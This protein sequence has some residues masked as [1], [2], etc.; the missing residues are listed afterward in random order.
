MTLTDDDP[1]ITRDAKAGYS[2]WCRRD[3]HLSCRTAGARCSCGCHGTRGQ[4][5]PA[6]TRP[7]ERKER[8]P[9]PDTTIDLR[10]PEPGCDFVAGRVQGLSRHRNQTHGERTNG[11]TPPQPTEKRPRPA[12]TTTPT[13]VPERQVLAVLATAYTDLCDADVATS[14]ESAGALLDAIAAAGWVVTDR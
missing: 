3:Q 5:P 12:P 4:T 7:P 9:M 6:T 13:A 11:A 14:I 2:S 10:C 8:L 1:P